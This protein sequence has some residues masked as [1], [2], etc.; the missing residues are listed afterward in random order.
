MRYARTAAVGLVLIT[1]VM[2][3][4]GKDG[5]DGDNTAASSGTSAFCATA[6]RL[7]ETPEGDPSTMSPQQVHDLLTKYY[8]D[9]LGVLDEHLRLAPEEIKDDAAVYVRV[10]RHIAETGDMSEFDTP[11]NLPAIKAHEAFLQRECGIEAP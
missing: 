8:T 5:N 6:E 4:C 11:A 3:G 2:A 9:R 7:N 10:A 1:A